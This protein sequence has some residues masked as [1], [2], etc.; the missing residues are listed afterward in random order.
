MTTIRVEFANAALE[1]GRALNYF[2]HSDRQKR[3]KSIETFILAETSLTNDEKS[4]AIKRLNMHYN[5]HNV[6]RCKKNLSSLSR[7]LL[8]NVILRA[9]H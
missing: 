8:S 7:I 1:K 4:F 5:Y 9:L 6:Q 3:T 2:I